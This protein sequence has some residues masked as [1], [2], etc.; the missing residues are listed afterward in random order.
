MEKENKERNEQQANQEYYASLAEESR[1]EK[2][3]MMERR[4][5]KMIN[6]N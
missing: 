2:S 3:I 6:E 1:K 5:E 4:G